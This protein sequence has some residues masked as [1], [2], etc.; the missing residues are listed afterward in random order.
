M[1]V[2][3]PVYS[4]PDGHRA[5]IIAQG[6]VNNISNLPV[7]NFMLQIARKSI[8]RQTERAEIYDFTIKFFSLVAMKWLF[9][10]IFMK[11]WEIG[12]RSRRY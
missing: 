2:K 6:T 10:K 12:N 5:Q 1:I 3:L 11:P 4:N 8:Q 7:K 9:L